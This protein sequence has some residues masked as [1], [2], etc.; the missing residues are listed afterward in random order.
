MRKLQEQG[1]PKN[2][3]LAYLTQVTL[4][5]ISIMCECALMPLR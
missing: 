3:L 4:G 2:G 5:M 1:R